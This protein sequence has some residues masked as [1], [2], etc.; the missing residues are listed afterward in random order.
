MKWKRQTGIYRAVLTFQLLLYWL[1]IVA[2]LTFSFLCKVDSIL[3]KYIKCLSSFHLVSYQQYS[4]HECGCVYCQDSWSRLK[5]NTGSIII[6]YTDLINAI[7]STLNLSI[8]R[9]IYINLFLK[10]RNATLKAQVFFLW[11]SEILYPAKKPI[12]IFCKL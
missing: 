6:V 7:W 10:I 3:W 11:V 4:Q 2:S 1:W 9:R 8:R 5:K 12:K